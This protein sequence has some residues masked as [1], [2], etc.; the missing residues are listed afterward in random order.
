MNRYACVCMQCLAN[1]KCLL[2]SLSSSSLCS[3][4]L[5]FPYPN[6]CHTFLYHHILPI[7]YSFPKG[8]VLL[9]LSKINSSICSLVPILYLLFKNFASVIFSLLYIINFH[10]HLHVLLFPTLQFYKNK[11]LF[12][13]PPLVHYHSIS[14]L[15]ILG[16][17]IERCIHIYFLQFMSIR[18]PFNSLYSGIFV[19][20]STENIL[21]TI[22]KSFHGAKFNGPFYVILFDLSSMYNNLPHTISRSMLCFQQCP[23]VFFSYFYRGFK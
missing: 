10:Q 3:T 13:M 7:S 6:F 23:S 9:L 18:L 8:N 16:K 20:M 21:D 5:I 12:L 11:Q 4:F 17:L 22:N 15:L 14:L 2:S 19:F 1:N